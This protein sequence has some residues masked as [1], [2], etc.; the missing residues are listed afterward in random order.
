MPKCAR[1]DRTYAPPEVLC[2]A[3]RQVLTEI[4]SR[5]AAHDN[6]AEDAVTGRRKGSF[7]R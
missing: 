2:A 3:Q 4:D 1:I 6:C 7:R 5:A